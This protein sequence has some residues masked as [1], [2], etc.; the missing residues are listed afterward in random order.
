[1]I[2]IVAIMKAAINTRKESETP[3]DMTRIVEDPLSVIP[4]AMVT[5]EMV[6][7]HLQDETTVIAAMM[8]VMNGTTEVYKTCGTSM[9]TEETLD[10]VV[11]EVT[12]KTTIALLQ[13]EVVKETIHTQVD[14]VNLHRGDIDPEIVS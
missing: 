10:E 14:D 13:P 3:G 6:G 7:D 1:V 12:T 2:V 9:E 5:E 8:S 4:G 11:M